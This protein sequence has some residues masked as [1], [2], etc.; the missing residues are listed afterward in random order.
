VATTSNVDWQQAVLVL[1]ESSLRC[2]LKH[3]CDDS[4]GAVV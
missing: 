2:H 3:G 4:V 1:N